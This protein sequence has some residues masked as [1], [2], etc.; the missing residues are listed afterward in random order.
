MHS[1]LHLTTHIFTTPNPVPKPTAVQPGV[2][3]HRLEI[4]ECMGRLPSGVDLGILGTEPRQTTEYDLLLLMWSKL[5]H[6]DYLSELLR[7]E[8]TCHGDHPLHHVR[9]WNGRYF[10]SKTLKELGLIVQL[11]HP[12]GKRCC[13]PQSVLKDE[14]VVMHRNGIHIVSLTF[15]N[16]ELNPPKAHYKQFLRMV[17]QW[18]HLKMLKCSGQGHD[19]A[20][21]LNTKEG[22]CAVLC[23]VCPQPRKNM[24]GSPERCCAVSNNE[25]NPSL[26][27]GWAYSVEDTMFKRYLSDH[28]HDIQ[29]KSMCSNHNA[30]NMADAK[31]KKGCD[32]T[33]IGMVVCARHGMRLQNGIVDLQ[34]GERYV[35]MDY[36]FASALHHSDV[37]VLKVS[38]DIACQWHKK[39]YQQMDQMPP[40]LQSNLH[41]WAVTFLIPK[42]HLPAH[43]TSCKWSFSFNWTKGVGQTDGEGP[44]CRWANLNLLLQA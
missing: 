29:E 6:E 9:E 16:T 14:F 10:T 34:Y 2:A 12:I 8:V 44:E 13:R 42:F 33:G 18:C 22:K 35:N 3:Y 1:A 17:H 38:Y 5:D 26:S 37:T 32:A 40:S 4:P 15:Y 20:G 11:G 31:S 30:V 41:D 7:L 25:N 21:V 27:Q 19:P 43:I 23:A 28:W 36:A 24:M 39:L